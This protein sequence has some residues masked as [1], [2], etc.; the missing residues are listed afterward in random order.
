MQDFLGVGVISQALAHL[1]SV[2][3]KH[4]P[5]HNQVL[6]WRR[7]KEMSSKHDQRVEPTTG[8]VNTLGDEIGGEC[9]LELLFRR[10]KGV[11]LLRVRHAAGMIESKVRSVNRCI[12]DNPRLT[13]PTRTNNQTPLPLAS[14]LP[15]PA[16]KGW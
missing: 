4:Q 8:L 3:S 9:T 16:W 7:V 10:A 13:F 12:D 6:P 1:L 2:A 5:R 14:N 11:V 15:C